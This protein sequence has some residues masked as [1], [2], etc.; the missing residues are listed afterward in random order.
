MYRKI[1]NLKLPYFRTINLPKFTRPKLPKFRFLQAGLDSISP[2]KK[3]IALLGALAVALAA[4]LLFVNTPPKENW[5]EEDFAFYST[6]G[7]PAVEPTLEAPAI[8]LQGTGLDAATY[9]GVKVGDSAKEALEKYNWKDFE[10]VVFREGEMYGDYD[11]TKEYNA[12]IAKAADL[13]KEMDEIMSHKYALKLRMQVYKQNGRLITRSYLK[14]KDGLQ[15]FQKLMYVFA[16]EIED[17]K[18]HT[19]VAENNYLKELN[20]CLED[21]GG[22]LPESD[23]YNWLR[24]LAE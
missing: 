13:V 18:V 16:L 11:L 7:K 4:A 3:R 12:K 8:V 2:S 20:S 22:L 10:L 6:E 23:E 21:N 15:P 14:G 24:L 9:R 1:K 19:I 17:G 5:C